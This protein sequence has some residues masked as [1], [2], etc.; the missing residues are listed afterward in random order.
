MATLGTKGKKK[1]LCGDCGHV[2]YLAPADA[3]ECINCGSRNVTRKRGADGKLVSAVAKK[4]TADASD[5][6]AGYLLRRGDGVWL[7][8]HG[9]YDEYRKSALVFKTVEDAEE[10]QEKQEERWPHFRFAMW[11][12]IENG[13]VLQLQH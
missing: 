1:H 10:A 8:T 6:V 11:R 2:L 5:A 13:G 12:F 4:A 3:Q 7:S 9:K